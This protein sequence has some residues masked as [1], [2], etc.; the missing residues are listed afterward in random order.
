[1][2]QQSNVDVAGLL[3]KLAEAEHQAERGELNPA[4]LPGLIRAQRLVR[5]LAGWPKEVDSDR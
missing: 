1:M 5:D 4:E 2:G 3:A